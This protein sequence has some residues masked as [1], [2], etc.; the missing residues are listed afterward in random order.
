MFF[1]SRCTHTAVIPIVC[2]NAHLFSF[3]LQIK[4]SRF[5]IATFCS[6]LKNPTQQWRRGFG[7]Q[8]RAVI[9][10]STIWETFGEMAVFGKID[11][12]NLYHE[13]WEEYEERLKHYFITD[14]NIQRSVLLSVVGAKTY[15]LIRN[16]VSPDKPADK[17]IGDLKT[18]IKNHLQP[19]PLTIAERFKFYQRK[20]EEGESVNQF[21][22][23]LCK[24]SEK[25]DFGGF[26]KDA[27]GDGLVC[28]LSSPS[29][30]KKLLSEAN[31][32]LDKRLKLL[33]P[34]NWPRKRQLS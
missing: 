32:T 15:S 4:T 27:L 10:Y 23:G 11:E 28:G 17:K 12:F 22:A 26:L 9:N 25:C 34:W 18:V 33:Y 2:G 31:F 1:G 19:N 8:Q 7:E 5:R 13:N 24:L 21:L 14:A 3:R 6:V 29:I 20:Q 30:Q 16:L